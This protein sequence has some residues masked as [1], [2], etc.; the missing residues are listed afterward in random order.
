MGCHVLSLT[1][2]SA[3]HEKSP[4]VFVLVLHDRLHDVAIPFLHFLVVHFRKLLYPV[5]FL[6]A[7]FVLILVSRH[8]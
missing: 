7:S 4:P 3:H 5:F 8:L 2:Y 1:S 6:H